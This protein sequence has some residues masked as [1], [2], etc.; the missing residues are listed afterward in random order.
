M[1]Y[2]PMQHPHF[3]LAEALR[4]LGAE[5]DQ[6][7][8][9]EVDWEKLKA[10]G[11]DIYNAALLAAVQGKKLGM[12]QE[13]INESIRMF[14]QVHGKLQMFKQLFGMWPYDATKFQLEK[15]ALIEK[16]LAASQY[17]AQLDAR[18]KPTRMALLS[19]SGGQDMDPEAFK[20]LALSAGWSQKEIRDALCGKNL[21]SLKKPAIVIPTTALY[22]GAV[23]VAALLAWWW[24]SRRRR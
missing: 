21:Y 2:R 23:V 10:L 4:G 8:L 6:V 19:P 12:D 7:G 17:Y 9:W 20:K 24:W 15:A 3:V 16:S 22:G 14:L 1:L 5:G 11:P 18:Y 13:T